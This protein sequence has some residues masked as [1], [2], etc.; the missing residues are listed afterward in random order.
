MGYKIFVSYKYADSNVKQLGNQYTA[1]DYV[2]YLQDHNFSGDDVNKA[3]NDDEDLSDFKQETIK[4]HLKDKIWDSSVTVVL[5]S[6][7]MKEVSKKEEDQWIPWEISYSLRHQKR[8]GRSSQPNALL[9][10]VLPDK[11]NSYEYFVQYW[12]YL[13]DNGSV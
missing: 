2:D 1:R 9:A 4:S 6:P 5:I 13:D 10:I 8:A 7:G 11:N 3:E 12:D